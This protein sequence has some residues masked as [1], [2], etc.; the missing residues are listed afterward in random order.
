MAAVFP[1]VAQNGL[2]SCENILITSFILGFSLDFTVTE[3]IWIPGPKVLNSIYKQ[4]RYRH[5]YLEYAAMG[6][7]IRVRYGTNNAVH[8]TADA[9]C[10]ERYR[11]LCNLLVSFAA[12]VILFLAINVGSGFIPRSYVMFSHR[13]VELR[14]RIWYLYILAV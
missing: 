11:K 6:Q 13:C 1:A 3:P 8:R 5:R 10:L 14:K 9:V 2:F 7:G 4:A 12:I